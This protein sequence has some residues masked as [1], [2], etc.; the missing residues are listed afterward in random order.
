M[1][2][3]RRETPTSIRLTGLEAVETGALLEELERRFDA[4]V[5]GMERRRPEGEVETAFYSAGSI[6]TC[7]G[8]L[9]R[10]QADLMDA[11][12]DGAEDAGGV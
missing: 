6:S 10:H 2:R 9:V 5:C 1:P 8:L 11:A 7:L 4:V 3:R 12:G